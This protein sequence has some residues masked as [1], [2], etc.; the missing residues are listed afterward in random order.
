MKG[1]SSTI[2]STAAVAMALL[3]TGSVTKHT[4]TA[5]TCVG[6]WILLSTCSTLKL[7]PD[8]QCTSIISAGLGDKVL[9]P[10]EAGYE[11]R[12]DSYWSVSARLRP[13]CMVL[14][15]TPDDVSTIIRVLVKEYCPF[16]IRGGGHGSFALSNGVER[17][18]TIDFGRSFPGPFFSFH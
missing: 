8:S 14:P 10:K 6:F 9:L 13:W 7:T 2:H 12:L 15:S 17:G 5:Q 4:P 18:V 3:T 1:Y 16:G 11:A